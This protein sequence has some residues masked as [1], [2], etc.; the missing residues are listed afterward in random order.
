MKYPY[1]IKN[2]WSDYTY[3]PGVFLFPQIHSALALWRLLY[4][5]WNGHYGEMKFI[6]NHDR[7]HISLYFLLHMMAKK[8]S[9]MQ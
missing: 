5:V 3:V 9:T 4:C 2:T 1:S 8:L 7:M 6:G